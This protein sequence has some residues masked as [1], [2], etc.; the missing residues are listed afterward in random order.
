MNADGPLSV[1]R[2]VLGTLRRTLETLE[3]GLVAVLLLGLLGLSFAQVV[4]RQFHGGWLW[5][6]PLI[7]HLVLWIA[8]AGG[9]LAASR[10]RHI[11]I[12]ALGRLL[13]G[14]AAVGL[15]LLLE[16]FTV[17]ISWRLAGAGLDL[18]KMS[19]EYGD[20]IDGLDWP[21][22]AMQAAIPVGFALIGFHALLNLTLLLAGEPL[23]PPEGLAPLVPLDDDGAAGRVEEA[24]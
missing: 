18:V 19:Q 9:A 15:R 5:A 3:T 8:F 7:R 16:A 13:K 24:R 6:D 10:S 20:R 22:W 2:R 23:P 1:V 11:R 14:R 21:A 12:D 4:L 17:W